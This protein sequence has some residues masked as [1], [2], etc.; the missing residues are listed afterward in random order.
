M[1]GCLFGGC[2]RQQAENSSSDAAQ[3][4]EVAQLL[5][6]TVLPEMSSTSPARS[7]DSYIG[8]AGLLVIF[9][10]THCP[11]VAEAK[12][13]LPQIVPILAK[14]DISTVMVNLD[15]DLE[16]VQQHYADHPYGIPVLY[17]TTTAT[18]DRWSITSV[19]TLVYI[20]ADQRA[21]YNGPASWQDLASAVEKHLK[22][23]A[24]TINFAPKGPGFG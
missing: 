20:T 18:K 16:D 12:R 22:L 1:M 21:D 24:G 14:R 23:T 4:P 17:D 7:L 19:P 9:V 10:D 11:F 8:K 3:G 15:N 5:Q 13:D 2:N 6:Q